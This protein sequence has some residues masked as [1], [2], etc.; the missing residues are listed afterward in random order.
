M[1][2][3]DDIYPFYPSQR[4]TFIFSSHL[5]IIILV[6]LVLAV[7]LLLILPGIR[8]KSRL[9]WMFRINISLFIGGVIVALNF[10][11][12]WAEARMTTN[13]T[14][15]SFSNAVVNA[16]IGLHVGLYGIN[17]TLKGN[18]VVQF[19]ET[20]DYNEMF[21]W[22]DSIEE[23][24]EEALG[25]GLPNPI[26]YIAEKFTLSSPCGLIFQYR[27]S[28]RY[29]S[30]TLWTAFCCW[31]L[32]N[33]LFSMPVILYAGYMMMATAAFIFFSVASFSTIMNVPQCVFSIGADSFET[34][35]SHS[36]WLALATGVLCA[37]IGI[38][39]VM[40]NFLIPEKMKD[41]FSIGVDS[42]EDDDFSNGEGY[43]NSVFL[44][45]VIT[46]SLTSEI[47][48]DYL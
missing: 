31:M 5:L 29:A 44:D 48:E 35:Y 8:G 22:H 40:F 32:A 47:T 17:V 11:N 28:G 19:N 30:A 38:L 18:P 16:E 27:Y 25:K 26:L 10:T 13:A 1:T 21:S 39:V 2:F 9:F 14:Y 12:N 15:K 24:Y 43:L 34:E 41:A 46:S 3:Y 6:F 42:C 45:G 23:E 7:S 36:F 20:I 37:I 33:I 4:T